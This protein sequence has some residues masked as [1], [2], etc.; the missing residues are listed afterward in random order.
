MT[1]TSQIPGVYFAVPSLMGV[2]MSKRSICIVILILLLVSGVF[3]GGGREEA[4]ADLQ[5]PVP[6]GPQTPNLPRTL[7]NEADFERVLEAFDELIAEVNPIIDSMIYNGM[8]ASSQALESLRTATQWWRTYISQL[9][10]NAE[11]P[12]VRPGEIDEFLAGLLRRDQQ[13]QLKLDEV[14]RIIELE[15]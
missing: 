13:L 2:T 8:E 4:Q 15:N 9:H 3:A 6:Q 11:S 14:N 5:V 1:W 10:I 7:S 12:K